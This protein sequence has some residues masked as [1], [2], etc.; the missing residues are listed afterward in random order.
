[1]AWLAISVFAAL[2]F[3]IPTALHVVP[4]AR[5]LD[6]PIALR[7]WPTTLV[8]ALLATTAAWLYTFIWEPRQR[9]VWSLLG[10]VTA[11]AIALLVATSEGEVAAALPAIAAVPIGLGIAVRLRSSNSPS[12]VSVLAIML[13]GSMEILGSVMGFAS[14]RPETPDDAFH[15]RAH[16]LLGM[17][18]RFVDLDG[19]ARVHYVDEGRGPVLLF[20][21][22][23]PAWLFQWR[24]FVQEL[25]DSYRCV[26]LDYPGFGLSS[27]PDT[28][29]YTPDEQRRL[30]EAFVNHLDLRDVTLVM[31]DWGGPIGLGFAE[32]RPDLVRRVI[33]GNTWAWPTSRTEPRGIFSVIAGGPIGEFL[34]VNFNGIVDAALTAGTVEPVS[35]EVRGGYKL[36]FVPVERRGIAAFYPGQI[37]ADADYMLEIERG[38]AKLRDRRAL[39]FWGLRDDGFP[40]ADLQRF[41]RAFPNHHT[42]EY[43]EADH[44]LVEDVA[45][46]LVPHIRA[47][48]EWK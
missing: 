35:E 45:H 42:V 36:P 9:S 24:A 6:F 34:Q 4:R 28:F 33:L 21:H 5:G 10:V 20:L 48:L 1:M 44:F 37:T 18:S 11:I 30:V 3:L 17:E 40:R 23:N 29:R 8:S 25:R 41:Q 14:E 31:H 12:L 19:G 39:I 43:D 7:L 15:A 13:V 2:A 32:L 38:L 16:E 27:A 22:G 46:Q 26:A 47:F